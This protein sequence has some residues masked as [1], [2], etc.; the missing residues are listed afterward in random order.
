LREAIG[1]L[2][3]LQGE[4]IQRYFDHLSSGTVAEGAKQKITRV[5]A[6]CQCNL[7]QQ[8]FEIYSLLEEELTCKHCHSREVSLVSRK[9]Y[10]V[11]DMDV[12]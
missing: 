10:L 8:S 9:E 7:C 2:S 1:V 3:D 6:V 11:K 12:L 4:W 5:P